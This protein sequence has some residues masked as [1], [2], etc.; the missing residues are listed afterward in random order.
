MADSVS[1]NTRSPLIELTDVSC[2][3]GGKPVLSNISW[4][5]L[6]GEHWAVLGSNGAGKTSFLRL[7]RGDLWPSP[8]YGKRT[9]Y[10]NGSPRTSPIGLKERTGLVSS[11][12]L[13]EYGRKGWNVSAGEVVCTGFSGSSFL[14]DAPSREILAQADRAMRMLGL[15]EL[16]P[17]SFLTL[18][19]GQA[20]KILIARAMVHKPALLC[21]DECCEGLDARSRRTVLNALQQ[22]AE[23][24]TQI[25]YATHR[26]SELL[27]V[28]GHALVLEEGRIVRRGPTRDVLIDH[29]REND[30]RVRES[31]AS[32]QVKAEREVHEFLIGVEG[33]DVWIL[34]K[35]I[36][37]GINWTVKPGEN[38]AVLGENGSGKTTLLQLLQGDRRAAFGGRV[39][40]FGSKDPKSIWE[41]RRR[42]GLVSAELQ[43]THGYRQSGLETVIS[44][45][46]GSIGLHSDP[47]TDQVDSARE[48]LE[49][50]GLDSFADRDI[51]ELSYGQVRKLLIA[52]AMVIRPKV[53]LLDEV[54]AGLDPESRSDVLDLLDRLPAAGTS[55]VYVTHY[56]ED[57]IPAL[58]HVMVMHE[59]KIAFQGTKLDYERYRHDSMQSSRR[60]FGTVL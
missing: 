54:A 21:L 23:A 5:L 51:Q 58:T 22:M 31:G 4:S 48:W 14:Y 39:R 33:A 44:G 35:K 60:S 50:L 8:G 49:F 1:D 28:I 41:I 7:V 10:L 18:S 43:T 53:L 42:I 52:R 26:P 29:R 24:G 11:E 36:L 59:G 55:I 9:Y 46:F 45:F 19:Q 37:C 47:T 32:I 17:Q 38:W 25:L 15:E 56:E 12:L 6:R 16:S 3:V 13:D 30:R 20:K 57:L 40:R 34:G 2:R 27:P